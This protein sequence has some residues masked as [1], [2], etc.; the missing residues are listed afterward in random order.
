[1]KTKLP[2]S[3]ILIGLLLTTLAACVQ[4]V[5]G[6][7][8]QSGKERLSSPDVSHAD[9]A[10][11]VKGNNACAFELYQELKSADNNIFY[12][13]YS[14]SLAL[15]MTYAGARNETEANG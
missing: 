7:I 9:L 11:I 1:M 5:S 4:P 6:E 14:M 12:S 13:P 3:V 2:F 8:L 10:T 15:A